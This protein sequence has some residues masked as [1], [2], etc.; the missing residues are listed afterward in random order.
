M[1]HTL[2][3][4]SWRYY[5]IPCWGRLFALEVQYISVPAFIC[6]LLL[7]HPELR[8]RDIRSPSAGEQRV[9]LIL[10]LL[11]SRFFLRRTLPYASGW[12]PSV[13]GWRFPG[14]FPMICIS[15]S[16]SAFFSVPTSIK[17]GGEVG[18]N[19]QSFLQWSA[20]RMSET[21]RDERFRMVKQY[22]QVGYLTQA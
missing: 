22:S 10:L 15:L 13:G 16:F 1:K 8:R 12:T 21:V 14:P 4:R 5:S 20:E 11:P 9:Q 6:D 7:H 19:I 3:N 17:R 18:E 2:N